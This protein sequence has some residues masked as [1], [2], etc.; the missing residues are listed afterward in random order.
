ISPARRLTRP[1]FRVHSMDGADAGSPL[2]G[3]SPKEESMLARRLLTAAF[4]GLL[5]LPAVRAEELPPDA[6]RV[7]DEFDQDA[8]TIR[9]KA[10][11]EVQAAK[12]KYL[13]ELQKLQETYTKAGKLDEALA[14]RGQIRLLRLDVSAIKEDPGNL[15]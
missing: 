12:E 1:D 13:K 10:N 11:K 3:V 9:D 6:R 5:I 15:F 14:I 7:I 2:K 4:V 8:R